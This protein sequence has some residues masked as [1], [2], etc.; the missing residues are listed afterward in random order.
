LRDFGGTALHLIACGPDGNNADW[1]RRFF[2]KIAGA[3]R[4]FN[5][6]IHGYGAH[7]Y[8]GTA[9]ASATEFSVDQWYELLERAAGVERLICEQRAVMDEFDPRREVGLAL[10]EWGTWHLPTAGRNAAHL[11]QQNT[12]RDALVAAITLDALNRNADKV[13][14]ANL[15]QAANV[16]QAL[17][18]TEGDRSV[19]TPTFHV[20]EMYKHHQG[21]R[22]VRVAVEDSPEVS[23]AAGEEKRRMGALAG[24]ASVRSGVMTLSVTNAHV[25]MPVEARVELPGVAAG[26]EVTTTTLTS[27]ELSAHNT[28]EAPRALEPVT[29]R[30]EW[31][32]RWTF[33]PASVTVVRVRPSV[34]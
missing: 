17:F 30:G 9:G 28:F 1:T 29:V 13:V 27:E 23:F 18:L 31:G 12:L 26:A 7:Y 21:G 14:M 24:S 2:R 33:L 19:L 25:R 32:G 34:G 3:D 11:W 8:C 6:R 20:F 22:G 16:L 5:C 4:R 10:D 15:A